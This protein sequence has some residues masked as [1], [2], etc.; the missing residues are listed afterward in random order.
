MEIDHN[1]RI[2]R[3]YLR[4]QNGSQTLKIDGPRNCNVGPFA[5][6]FRE[7]PPR[8]NELPLVESV[9]N[10]FI[11]LVIGGQVGNSPA[12]HNCGFL[13]EGK[14]QRTGVSTLTSVARP[15]EHTFPVIRF[16]FGDPILAANTRATT[17]AGVSGEVVDPVATE[18]YF[19]GQGITQARPK[20]LKRVEP[21]GFRPATWEFTN[22]FTG[23]VLHGWPPVCHLM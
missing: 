4:M 19:R 21:C 22:S 11:N 18:V 8:I 2:F 16:N 1:R 13:E 7:A 6:T 3:N 17:C 15:T 20:I 23:F 9:N 14:N 5:R 12:P 10:E